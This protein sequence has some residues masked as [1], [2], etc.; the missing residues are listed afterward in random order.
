MRPI[1]PTDLDLVT[2]TLLACDPPHRR[3]LARR[4]VSNAETADRY[5]KRTG[6]LHPEFG[7][8]TLG[9]AAQ[10]FPRARA[11]AHCDAPYRH[12]LLILLEALAT[13]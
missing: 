10:G 12:C 8:G 13:P 7:A 6:R 2:R 11:L 3:D 1:H 9:S 4:I 5:R